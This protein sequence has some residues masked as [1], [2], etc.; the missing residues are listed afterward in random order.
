L[1]RT[2]KKFRKVLASALTREPDTPPRSRVRSVEP[3]S[4]KRGLNDPT[5][6]IREAIVTRRFL[7]NE[8]LIEEDLV[9]LFD[10]NRSAIRLAIA[11]LEQEG[12]LV[13]EANRGARV[14]LLSSAEAIEITEARA[15]LESLIA[16]HAA[17]KITPPQVARLKAKLVQLRKLMNA[18]DLVPYASEN[19]EFHRMIIQIADHSIAAKMLESLSAQS[20]VSQFRPFLE[21]GRVEQLLN[22]HEH[23]VAVLAS[24]DPDAAERSMRVHLDNATAA[25]DRLT[26][27]PGADG[28]HFGSVC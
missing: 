9:R 23:L 3:Y 28:G 17:I 22:E 21:Q 12:L 24:K 27:R 18:R 6:R 4:V 5:S 20:V 1:L 16:R 13:R 14:R 2:R 11:R 7:P 25:I 26:R 8:R 19:M 10:A 15:V